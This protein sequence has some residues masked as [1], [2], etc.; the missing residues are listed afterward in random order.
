MMR[1]YFLVSGLVNWETD[2]R[3]DRFP[4]DYAPI[5]YNFFG[6][7]SCVSGVGCNVAKALSTLGGRV[8]LATLLG[9]DVTADIALR[10]LTAA[11]IDCTLARRALKETPASTVLYDHEG[12]RRI[13]CDL[14]DIQETAYDFDSV[15]LSVFD[16]VIACNINFSRPLLHKAKNA[17]IPVAVDVHTLSDIHDDYNSEFMRYADI[18]FLS[19]EK[20]PCEPQA[21]LRTIENAYGCRIIVL[22]Q[23]GRGALMYVRDEDRFYSFTAARLGTPI[24]TVG[25]GDSLFSSFVSLYCEGLAPVECLKRAEVFAAAKIL[26]SG[27]SNGFVTRERL[28]ELYAGAA[29]GICEK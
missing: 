15:D 5:H 23:G 27:A 13:E 1:Q 17:G 6:V 9:Q 28:E 24:N 8:T 14:K 12:R 16:A 25:A 29:P 20:L 2:C 10:E 19:D 11:G 7:S 4:I 26:T 21:F 3:V 22:G 18:L